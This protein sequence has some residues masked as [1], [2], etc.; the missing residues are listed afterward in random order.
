MFAK[1]TIA[2]F[3]FLGFVG[4]VF[5]SLYHNGVYR[6]ESHEL[7]PTVILLVIGAIAFISALR[8]L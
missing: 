6:P 3:I 2:G 5:V 1:L 7:F 4:N 8:E